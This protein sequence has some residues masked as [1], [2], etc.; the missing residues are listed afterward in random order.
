MDVPAGVTQEESHTGFLIHLPSAVLAALV[1]LAGRIWPFLS[2]GDREV[3]LC[4][5]K[6]IIFHLFFFFLFSFSSFFSFFFGEENP[7]FV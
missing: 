2:L 4:T 1:F 6:L 3:I 5:N 7:Q